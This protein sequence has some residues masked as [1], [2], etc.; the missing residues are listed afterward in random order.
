[1]SSLKIITL[2]N[3]IYIVLHLNLML[4]VLNSINISLI[5][6]LILLSN[7][8]MIVIIDRNIN[9]FMCNLILIFYGMLCDICCRLYKLYK[10]LYDLIIINIQ[11]F[12]WIGFLSLIYYFIVVN[13]NYI[14]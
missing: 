6:L 7:I 4:I 13:D 12:F 9:K 8:L 5:K 11:L 3:L 14:K 10:I 1:M 2:F